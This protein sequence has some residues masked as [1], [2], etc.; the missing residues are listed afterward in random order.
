MPKSL[1]IL[2]AVLVV[3][4]YGPAAQANTFT[5]TYTCYGACVGSVP[6]AP[7]VTFPS[8]TSITETWDTVTLTI[9]LTVAGVLPTDAWGWESIYFPTSLPTVYWEVNE[10]V[11][12]LSRGD[13]FL[14]YTLVAPGSLGPTVI[15]DSGPLTFTPT[16][17][18]TPEPSLAGLMLLGIGFLAVM[19]KHIVPG[20]SL[21]S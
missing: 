6:T 1:W 5:P 10:W 19:R 16:T 12:D 15:N 3:A 20:R 2:L 21:A 4:I 8:P 14:N 9:D 18:V 7:D 11:F 17:V 13:N